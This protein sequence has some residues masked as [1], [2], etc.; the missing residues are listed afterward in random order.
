VSQEVQLIGT[1]ELYT[2]NAQLLSQDSSLSTGEVLLPVHSSMASSSCPCFL[3]NCSLAIPELAATNWELPAIS[4]VVLVF[5][6]LSGLML[7]HTSI[8]LELLSVTQE[9]SVLR[10]VSLPRIISLDG[11]TQ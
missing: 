9:L 8:W 6:A 7:T 1:G 4:V 3:L 5:S 2:Q 10:P 11:S